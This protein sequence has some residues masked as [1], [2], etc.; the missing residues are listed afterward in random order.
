MGDLI[1][2]DFRIVGRFQLRRRFRPYVFDAC[3]LSGVDHVDDAPVIA[4]YRIRYADD[5]AAHPCGNQ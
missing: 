3:T 1:D 4:R 2:P 5:R